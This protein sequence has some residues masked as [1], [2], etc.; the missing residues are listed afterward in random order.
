MELPNFQ[1]ISLHQCAKS[2]FASLNRFYRDELFQ[3]FFGKM[4]VESVNH[5]D[6]IFNHTFVVKDGGQ[7]LGY[8]SIS[9]RIVR[10]DVMATTIYYGISP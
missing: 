1:L 10:E 2:D 3:N 9:H 8:L 6:S 7:F 4:Q 5:S